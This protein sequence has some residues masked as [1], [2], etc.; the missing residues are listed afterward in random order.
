MV[1]RKNLVR[2]F[3]GVNDCVIHSVSDARVERL[4][5]VHKNYPS[6]KTV[7]NAED[8]IKDSTIDA[9]VIATP[10]FTHFALAKKALENGK[11][12]PAEETL[13]MESRSS[14]LLPS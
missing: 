7:I 1:K 11:L 10:V 2:N 9:L 14:L 3:F 13:H 6:I 4:A 12:L 5:L 8:V